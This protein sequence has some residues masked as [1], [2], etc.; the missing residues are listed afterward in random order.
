MTDQLTDQQCVG[1]K[2]E[3]GRQY[4]DLRPIPPS[5]LGSRWYVNS[6]GVAGPK[7]SQR[8]GVGHAWSAAFR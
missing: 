6:F 5:G 4:K 1:R 8:L 3:S 2:Y 7:M